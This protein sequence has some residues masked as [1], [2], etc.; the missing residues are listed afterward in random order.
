MDYVFIDTSV[1]ESENFL[2]G[3]KINSL[4]SLAQSDEIIILL[5]QLT[6]EE[7]KNRIRKRCK[8]SFE[9]LKENKYLVLKNAK[10]HNALFN[11]KSLNDTLYWTNRLLDQKLKS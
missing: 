1:F 7:I 3:N 8:E 2:M 5:P 9:Y 6:Y 10:L 4:F 11:L